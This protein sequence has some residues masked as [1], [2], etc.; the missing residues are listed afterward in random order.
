MP[1]HP[2][3]VV[4]N[5]T[6][7]PTLTRL[8]SGAFTTELRIAAS[9][10]VRDEEQATGWRDIDHLFI[11]GK[12]WGQL[13]QNAKASLRKGMPVIA[14]G[15]IVT[16]EWE[17]P[18]P[19]GGDSIKRQKITL[20]V[21]RIGL[22]LTKYVVSSLRTD[23]VEHRVDGVPAPGMPEADKIVDRTVSP[24]DSA[25]DSAEE[26]PEEPPH[27]PE[28]VTVGGGAGEGA[29]EGAAEGTEQGGGAAPF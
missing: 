1:Q 28:L 20:K 2:I 6:Y 7:D 3:T 4:G 10:S 15:R 27:D 13:A 8:P 14:T 22:D 23:V 25:V 19:L 9:R 17:E 12:L 21:E 29:G 11:T 5:L 16:D 24:A 18:H 26:S